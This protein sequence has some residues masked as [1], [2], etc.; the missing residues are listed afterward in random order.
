MHVCGLGL[1]DSSTIYFNLL[2]LKSYFYLFLYLICHISFYNYL[3]VESNYQAITLKKI[4]NTLVLYKLIK[5]IYSSLTSM[6][7][8]DVIENI[9]EVLYSFILIQED[10]YIFILITRSL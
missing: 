5:K 1:W 3:E 4:C 9:T 7:V 2:L 6:V 10:N 8:E